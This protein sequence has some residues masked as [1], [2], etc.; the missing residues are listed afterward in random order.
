MNATDYRFDSY[1]DQR[2]L[3]DVINNARVNM[4]SYEDVGFFFAIFAVMTPVEWILINTMFHYN[5]TEKW[6]QMKL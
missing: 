5:L 1:K 6:W 3:Y 4:P 2:F